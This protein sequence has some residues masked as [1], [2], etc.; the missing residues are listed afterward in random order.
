LNSIIVPRYL[1][2]MELTPQNKSNLLQGKTITL[3]DKLGRIYE[4]DI[5]LINPK[6]CVLKNSDQKQ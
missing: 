1:M 2:D 3:E 5:D 6:G 4:V